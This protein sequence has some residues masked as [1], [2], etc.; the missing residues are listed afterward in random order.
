MPTCSPRSR[1]AGGRIYRTHGLGYVLRRAASGHTWD[2]G[3]G[4]FLDPQ[5]VR[6]QWRGFHPSSLLELDDR[7]RPAAQPG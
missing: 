6:D 4:H 3:L 7:D 1:S 5:R 2:P